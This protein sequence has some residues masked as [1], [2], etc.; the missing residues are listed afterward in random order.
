MCSTALN[1]NDDDDADGVGVGCA[2]LL[3][4][5]PWFPG[6]S[7]IDQ[8]SRVF[9]VLGT[10]TEEQWAKMKDLPQYLA[11]SKSPAQPLRT[12]F[13]QVPASRPSPGLGP[14]SS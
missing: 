2:E 14:A 3:L 10:P 8:L 4:R 6:S 5:R 1:D 12:M 11:F 9:Q 13:R 7:D